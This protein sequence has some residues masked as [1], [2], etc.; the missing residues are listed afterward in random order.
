M[1]CVYLIVCCIAIVMLPSSYP[2]AILVILCGLTGL[3]YE[4]LHSGADLLCLVCVR[5]FVVLGSVT[6]LEPFDYGCGAFLLSLY[7]IGDA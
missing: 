7:H 6:M 4:A 2:Y 3:C 1:F 5:H